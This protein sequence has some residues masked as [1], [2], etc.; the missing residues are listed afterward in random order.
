MAEISDGNL[1]VDGGGTHPATVLAI[2]TGH[3]GG[4]HPVAKTGD[5]NIADISASVE[6]GDVTSG[7]DS[8]GRHSAVP[9]LGAGILAAVGALN[10]FPK[11]T[12]NAH[13]RSDAVRAENAL[14]KKFTTEWLELLPSTRLQLEALKNPPYNN[15]WS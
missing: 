9:A 3:S 4:T 10:R 13:A 1:C 14:S 5:T 15:C 7:V 12:K 11:R 2:S 8:G 6:V